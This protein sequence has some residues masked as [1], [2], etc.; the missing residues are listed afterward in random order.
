MPVGR[1]GYVTLCVAQG[2]DAAQEW[3]RN[4]MKAVM[5]YLPKLVLVVLIWVTTIL[6]YM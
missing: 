1:D 4:R 5:E 6:V 3:E 2:T